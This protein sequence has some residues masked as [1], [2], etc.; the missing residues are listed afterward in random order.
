MNE[1]AHGGFPALVEAIAR[2]AG[3]GA[4]NVVLGAGADDLILLC[5]RTF[6]GP[7]DVVAIDV[8]PTL[9]F[10]LGIPGPQNARG[11]IRYDIVDGT[12]DTREITILDISDY[13]GQLV[14][15]TE[16]ADNLTATGTTN[17]LFT[18]G[19]SAFLK[20]WFDVWLPDVTVHRVRGRAGV[21]SV[22]AWVGVIGS[23]RRRSRS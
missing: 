10:V 18:I 1:Y 12:S 3:V 9:S 22:V 15:L 2:Y 20:P 5:A 17:P 8:A 6:A 4:D 13:H 7:G 19:G 16:A 21:V 11:R 23:P 14:P